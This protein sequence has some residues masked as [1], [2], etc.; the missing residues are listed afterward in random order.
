MPAGVLPAGSDDSCCRQVAFSSTRVLVC[1]A[2]LLYSRTRFPCYPDTLAFMPHPFPSPQTDWWSTDDEAAG[3]PEVPGWRAPAA[4]RAP[5]AF[6][7]LPWEDPAWHAQRAAQ[8]VEGHALMC[9]LH[10]DLFSDSAVCELFKVRLWRVVVA[11]CVK[12]GAGV[13]LL[14][15]TAMSLCRRSMDACPLRHMMKPSERSSGAV[16]GMVGKNG[17]LAL[18]G[19]FCQHAACAGWMHHRVRIC[20]H[21]G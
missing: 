8:R 14:T 7:C 6:A 15:S 12:L 1:S 16:V 17:L 3:E 4:A 19:P 18:F 13:R 2:G 5:A 10:K 11:R 21:A 9:Q 20:T